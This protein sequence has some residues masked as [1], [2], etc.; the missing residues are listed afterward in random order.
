[1][2]FGDEAESEIASSAVK[3]NKIKSSHIALN[4]PKLRKEPIK[5][6]EG[7]EQDKASNQASENERKKEKA[8]ESVQ[9]ALSKPGKEAGNE[10]ESHAFSEKMRQNVIS[11]KRML[12][13]ATASS[14]EDASSK[15]DAEVAEIKDDGPK[16]IDELKSREKEQ[17]HSEYESLKKQILSFKQ[18]NKPAETGFFSQTPFIFLNAS[19]IYSAKK[20]NRTERISAF[21]IC[22]RTAIKI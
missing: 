13:A 22:R 5:E 2:S 3:K 7:N 14:S 17:R 12:E 15:I 9:A 6:E 1:M 20:K 4:D 11:H 10:K 18:A 16:T 21:I 19:K 8:R